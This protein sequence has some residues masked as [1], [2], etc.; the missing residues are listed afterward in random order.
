M[1]ILGQMRAVMIG[2]HLPAHVIGIEVKPVQERAHGI[3]R[4]LGLKRIRRRVQKMAARRH[5]FAR[6]GRRRVLLG[7]CETA[8][9]RGQWNGN[10]RPDKSLP[11]APAAGQGVKQ[12]HGK[13]FP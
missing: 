9:R 13:S 6:D 4:T 10:R 3:D 2:L 8:E 7:A 5:R 12:S 1:K 11:D